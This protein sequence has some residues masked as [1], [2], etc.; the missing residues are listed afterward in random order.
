[1]GG[2]V[3]AALAA[4][5]GAR[6]EAV[7]DP[8]VVAATARAPGGA[9]VG[10]RPGRRRHPCASDRA[11]CPRPPASA[12]VRESAA[13]GVVHDVPLT[14]DLRAGPVGL[15]GPSAETRG[16]RPGDAPPAVRA[17]PAGR[18]RGDLRPR[19][20]GDCGAWHWAALAA[21]TCTRQPA[22]R[23]GRCRS[24]TTRRGLGGRDAAGLGDRARAAGV[25]AAG[26]LRHVVQLCRWRR[27]A[28]ASRCA[29]TSEPDAA[30]PM[31]TG[32]PA[33]AETV[34]RDLAAARR[35]R[36]RP[37]GRR[38]PFGAR[39]STLLGCPAADAATRPARGGRGDAPGGADTVLGRG[40]DGPFTLDLDARRAARAG[41]RHDRIRQVRAAA[42]PGRRAGAAATRPTEL[43]F[44]L[45]DYKGGAAFGDVRA[46]AAL[47]R[48]WSPT[49]TPHLTRR[50]LRS[51]DARAAPARA[52]ARR[53]RR[54]LAGTR[55][56][57]GA[58]AR[59]RPAGDRRRRVRD[60][61]RRAARL[62]AR[63]G[64]RSRSAAA[65]SACTSCSRPSGPA[66]PCR[67]RSAPTPALRIALRVTDAAE[68]R[69][70]IDADAAARLPRDRRA[71]RVA[72]A[73][74]AAACCS[75]PRRRRYPG[76][77]PDAVAS[78][79]SDAWRRP[80][81][82]PG[83]TRRRSPAWST[84]CGPPPPRGP[85]RR[86]RALVATAAGRCLDR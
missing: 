20:R 74:G 48:R 58:G 8:V 47:R 78:T 63:A 15:A 39:C 52:G 37:A 76:R 64:R 17:A 30:P 55:C 80:P 10:A 49:S 73:D 28:S 35:R 79:P 29:A 24:S 21:A 82:D 31:R 70:V 44:L 23:A 1:M 14:V 18:G 69:D 68:S 2:Q 67:P 3:T 60:P 72:V 86:P 61:G 42:D 43:T 71:G 7:P 41:R 45:V 13:A 19:R 9:P 11:T 84:R 53:R 33:W 26:G 40:A 25:P 66:A 83:Q 4:E 81:A 51:L 75:R 27:R 32:S 12:P 22:P 77:P 65:R 50:A 62:R 54:R 34:A 5:T 46:A 38:C 59:A 6:R 56:R 85:S 16:G 57:P 36:R